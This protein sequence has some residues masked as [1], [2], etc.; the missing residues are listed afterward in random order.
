MY[1]TVL[2]LIYTPVKQEALQTESSQKFS[3]GKKGQ[4]DS[5]ISR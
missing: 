3:D 5:K 1:K 2:H 4:E